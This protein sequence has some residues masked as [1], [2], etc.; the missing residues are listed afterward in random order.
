MSVLLAVITLLVYGLAIFLFL[1]EGTL[2]YLLVLLAGHIAMLSTPLWARL[3]RFV[4]TEETGLSIFGLAQVPWNLVLGGGVLLVLPA[5]IFYYGL[6]HGFWACH[7]AALWGTYIVFALY[8]LVYER[9]FA[10]LI[11]LQGS[12][13]EVLDDTPFPAPFMIALLL[14]GVSL[15]IVYVV[16][17]TRHFAFH[18]AVM[19]L[20]LSGL[21]SM[22][23]FLG[24][25]ASPL[26]IISLIGLTEVSMWAIWG[27][28]LISLGLV[29]WGIHLLASVLHA[30]RSQ[31]FVWR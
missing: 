27:G 29:L 7:Y 13:L 19:P 21:I 9:L 1:R 4:I 11:S 24:I 23:V 16:V 18:I 30:G 15:G 28:I 25:F 17:S 14:A 31:H 3:Y 10:G 5:L 8:F 22:L 12:V 20:L 6:R 2:R 26:W